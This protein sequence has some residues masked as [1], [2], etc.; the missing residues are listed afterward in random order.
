MA[1]L[2]LVALAIGL[3]ALI[4]RATKTKGW[5]AIVAWIG[6]L[7]IVTGICVATYIGMNGPQDITTGAQALL[8]IAFIC[9]PG[10][11]IAIL[12]IVSDEVLKKRA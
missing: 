8:S 12:G 4:Y 5:P 10:L 1:S 7:I 2:I 3:I 11:L 6:L 9:G